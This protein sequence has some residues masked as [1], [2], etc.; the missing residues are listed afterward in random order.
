MLGRLRADLPAEQPSGSEPASQ[1]PYKRLGLP[2]NGLLL[3]KEYTPGLTGRDGDP[4]FMSIFKRLS[5]MLG[6][7][8]HYQK[9]VRPPACLHCPFRHGCG[10]FYSHCC[11]HH[12][13]H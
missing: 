4:G 7:R 6:L 13:R 8:R 5:Q 2:P 11:L 1:H 12:P 9:E 3:Y 10:A